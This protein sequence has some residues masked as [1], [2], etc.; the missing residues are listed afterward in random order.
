MHRSRGQHPVDGARF[1]DFHPDSLQQFFA[2]GFGRPGGQDRP[3]QL[4]AGI[5]Q[6]RLD[7]MDS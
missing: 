3:A 7:G 6:S 2:Q 1:H 5:G 4:A